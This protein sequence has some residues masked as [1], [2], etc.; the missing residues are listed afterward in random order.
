MRGGWSHAQSRASGGA[1]KNQRPIGAA[2]MET[3]C[4]RLGTTAQA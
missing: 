1:E 2:Q 4:K 3:A